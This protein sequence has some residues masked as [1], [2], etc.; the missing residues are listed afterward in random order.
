MRRSN[1]RIGSTVEVSQ[2]PAARSNSPHRSY[3]QMFP[4]G[5]MSIPA[6]DP[7]RRPPGSGP[8]SFMIVGVG[9]GSGLA[10]E[11]M[12]TGAKNCGKPALDCARSRPSDVATTAS[13]TRAAMQTP[14][15]QLIRDSA[16]LVLLLQTRNC[17]CLSAA[18]AGLSY[19][20][21][22]RHLQIYRLTNLRIAIEQFVNPSI[23]QFVNLKV[24]VSPCLCGP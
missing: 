8:H 6:D 23:R 21:S 22:T 2:A 3:A 20:G 13:P 1:L 19:A 18:D 14:S 11:S 4:S 9:L 5:P 7:H 17:C 16:I 24:S 12:R 10:A 15:S